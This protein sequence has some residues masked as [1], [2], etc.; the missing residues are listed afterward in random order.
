MQSQDAQL[1]EW[2]LFWQSDQL[3]SCVPVA[4]SGRRNGLHS[5]WRAFFDSLPAGARILDLGTGNGSLASQ[6]AAVSRARPVPFS[7]HGVDLA[8]IDPAR[9]VSSAAELLKEVRFHPRIP[10]E[11]LPFPNGRFDAV[12]S[13]YALEYSDVYRSLREALRVLRPEGSFRFLLHA[14]SGVLK[15]RCRGQRRQARAILDSDLFPCLEDMLE[16]IV[17]AERRRSPETLEAATR[18]IAALKAVFDDLESGLPDAGDRSVADN[19]FAAVRRL[20]GLRHAHGLEALIRMAGDIRELLLA[21][22]R[23]LKAMEEAALDRAGAT[24][25]ADELRT[26]GAERVALEHA[27]AGAHDTLVGYWLH[28]R[29][30]ADEAR[31]PG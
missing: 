10:M 11:A 7:I 15:D 30:P 2:T 29:K 8:D 26:I 20:P 16:K 13:Q 27:T 1:R 24:R 3:E 19:L 9:F 23:R 4:D 17:R 28:G 6:A 18:A 5:V 12:C 31:E 21:Q 14:D 22:E 25:L